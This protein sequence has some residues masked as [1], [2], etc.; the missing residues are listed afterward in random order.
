MTNILPAAQ[1]DFPQILFAQRLPDRLVQEEIQMASFLYAGLLE[2][3][4]YHPRR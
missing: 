1:I 3:S 2:R 4:Q